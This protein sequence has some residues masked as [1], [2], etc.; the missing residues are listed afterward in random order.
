MFNRGKAITYFEDLKISPAT[1]TLRMKYLSA[2]WAY[3]LE[4][5]HFSVRNPMPGVKKELAHVQQKRAKTIEP[6]KYQRLFAV[7]REMQQEDKCNQVALLV[8]EFLLYVPIRKT[9]ALRAKESDL[10]GNVLTIPQHKAMEKHDTTLT[11]ELNN[12]AMRV[13]K[14]AIKLKKASGL[15]TNPYIF[16]SEDDGKHISAQTLHRVW[17]E[18]RTRVGVDLVQHN[19]RSAIIALL[20]ER[21][22]T[23]E[24]ISQLTGQSV[25]TILIYYSPVLKQ[26]A[27]EL[28]T[29]VGD[30]IDGFAKP[31]LKV[32]K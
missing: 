22:R 31:K 14:R 13:I 6:D 24:E 3:G 25:A 23:A 11:A 10:N 9:E 18:L 28:S 27:R 7:L 15:A 5:E 2:A 30:I 32:M 4:R 16:A 1:R 26:K 12:G 19:T 21:G 17:D 8:E 20:M 29:E